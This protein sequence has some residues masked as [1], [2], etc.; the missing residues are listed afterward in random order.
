[1]EFELQPRFK[2]NDI[3]AYSGRN[4]FEYLMDDNFN[5]L[6]ERF[7]HRS[8]F[9]TDIFKDHLGTL[10]SQVEVF[11]DFNASKINQFRTTPLGLAQKYGPVSI[12]FLPML[13]SLKSGQQ[14][15]TSLVGVI[16]LG[17][18]L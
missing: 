12:A 5:N 18:D 2:I 17:F 13:L 11:Y 7:R 9:R 3:L 1:L 4:R 8:S 6:N 10:I 15:N 16:E 14:W